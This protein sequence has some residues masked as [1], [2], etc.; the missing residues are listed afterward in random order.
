ML[1][2]SIGLLSYYYRHISQGLYT[3]PYKYAYPN[4]ATDN[5]EFNTTFN[6]EQSV[7]GNGYFMTY[8]YAHDREPCEFKDYVHGSGS[9]D[10][11][12]L[13][14]SHR[15]CRGTLTPWV[16]TGTIS[17]SHAS[18]TRKITPWSMLQ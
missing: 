12:P 7:Q 16:Q 8:K 9:I 10:G 6:F 17:T 13:P 1:A 14:C 11:V 2:A 3:E 15:I 4:R 5:L 18:G